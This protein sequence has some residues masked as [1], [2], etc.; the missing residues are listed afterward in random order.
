MARK[1]WRLMKRPNGKHDLVPLEKVDAWLEK[2]RPAKKR[3]VVLLSSNVERGSWVV[4]LIDGKPTLVEK[5]HAQPL[6]KG[7][8]LQVIRDIEPFENVCI[9]GKIVGGRRQRRDMMR[10]YGVIEVGNEAPINHKQHD[11]FRPKEFAEDMKSAYRQHG[12]DIL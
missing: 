11:E 8:G 9:D 5:R 3:S 7:K 12:V 1:S 10:A 4:R 6:S 2:H